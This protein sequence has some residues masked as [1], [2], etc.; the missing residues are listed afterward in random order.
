MVI[1]FNGL[2]KYLRCIHFEMDFA[3]SIY[4]SYTKL[5]LGHAHIYTHFV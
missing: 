3:L 5:N 4:I 2:S 1:N